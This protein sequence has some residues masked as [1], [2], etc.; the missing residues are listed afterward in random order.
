MMRRHLNI[1]R[2]CYKI[3]VAL[4]KPIT[5]MDK[6]V[7]RTSKVVEPAPAERHKPD[8]PNQPKS[9]PKEN[10]MMGILLLDSRQRWWEQ[11]RDRCV[12]CVLNR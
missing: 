4:K 7:T 6:F 12:F 1:K 2:E 5:N 9:Q 3:T 11:R 8:G 10:M